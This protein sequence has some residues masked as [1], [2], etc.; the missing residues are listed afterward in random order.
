V[1]V[2]VTA[3]DTPTEEV[4][5]VKVAEVAPAETVTEAGSAA[6]LELSLRVTVAPP[7]GAGPLSVT[8]PV[9]LLPPT[10]IAG[11]K[12]NAEITTAGFTVSEAGSVTPPKEAERFAVTAELTV[13]V[14]MLNVLLVA[15]AAIVT[16]D[17]TLTAALSLLSVTTAP[18]PGAGVLRLTVPVAELPPV[19]WPGLTLKEDN[20]VVA[21]PYTA[22]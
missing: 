12:L 15:P 4:V 10:T 5:A 13:D 7:A 18:P 2:T 22:W 14:V 21:A 11:S 17:G 6:A 1:A 20:T 16:L 3:V 19:T 8:V 9:E